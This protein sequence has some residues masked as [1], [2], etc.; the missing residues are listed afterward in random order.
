MRVVTDLR[1]DRPH[2]ELGEAAG[3]AGSNHEQLSALGGPQE[4]LGRRA[5]D[6]IDVDLRRGF[7]A[8]RVQYLVRLLTR[9]LAD[10]L[11]QRL[12]LRL[13]DDAGPLAHH[14]LV[15]SDHRQWHLAKRRLTRSPFERPRGVARAIDSDDDPSHVF[16]LPTDICHIGTSDARRAAGVGQGRFVWTRRDFQAGFAV[17]K[18]P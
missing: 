2:N 11:G 7:L 14:G 16:H 3:A 17:T 18:G 9:R 10:L 1:A 6:R 8:E 13:A 5:G 12:V 4:L 15:N